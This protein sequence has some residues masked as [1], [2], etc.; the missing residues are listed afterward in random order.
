[1]AAYQDYWAR[2]L[3]RIWE[4][5]REGG[6]TKQ[7]FPLA[8]RERGMHGM[9]RLSREVRSRERGI[10][11]WCARDSEAGEGGEEQDFCFRRIAR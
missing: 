8:R 7:V 4:L 2:Y 6:I 10:G 11:S 1:M 3:Y 5:R 9:Q